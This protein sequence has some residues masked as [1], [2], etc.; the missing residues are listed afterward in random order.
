MQ[1][2]CTKF[3]TSL[4]EWDAEEKDFYAKAGKKPK[5]LKTAWQRRMQYLSQNQITEKQKTRQ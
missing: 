3:K 4:H 2:K 5:Y 1:Q